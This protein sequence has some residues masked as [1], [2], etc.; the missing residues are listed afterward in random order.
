ML[1]RDALKVSILD[2]PG[3]TNAFAVASRYQDPLLSRH[4]ILQRLG[5]PL[6]DAD[7]AVGNP[8]LK[9]KKKRSWCILHYGHLTNKRMKKY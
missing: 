3:E 7:S 4:E 6:S 5:I 9:K 2:I 8:F 1:F